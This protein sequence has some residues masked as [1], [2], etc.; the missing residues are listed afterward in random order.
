VTIT[1]DLCDPLRTFAPLAV[2]F[3]FVFQ[4]HAQEK[5][6]CVDGPLFAREKALIA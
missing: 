2:N 5:S 3:S 1:K 4:M 6:S